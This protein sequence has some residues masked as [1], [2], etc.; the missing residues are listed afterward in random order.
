MCC[1]A[2]GNR[3]PVHQAVTAR[4][5]TIPDLEADATSPAGRMA[6]GYP[7]TRGPSFRPVSGLPHRQQSLLQSSS[8]S[9]A[10]LRWIGPVRPRGSR[11]L[12]KPD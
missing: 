8:A 2:G 3:T 1:G 11:C 10:G 4:A 9:G 5:T 6:T 12:S 7:M